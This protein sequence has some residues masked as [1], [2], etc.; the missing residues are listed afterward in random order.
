LE[1]FFSRPIK[2]QSYSWGTGT[3][4]FEKF[5]P[6]QDYFENPRVIN[7]IVNYNL[8]RCKLHVKFML[9]GNGFHYG[10]AIASYLP[11]H[12]FDEFTK[13]RAFFVEDVV[14][15][16]QRPHVY[17]DPTKSQG[18][19][20]TLPFVWEANA[21]NIPLQQW[22]DMGQIIIH[23]MQ[24]LKHANGASDSVTVSA[25]VWAT[26]YIVGSHCKRT[27]CTCTTIRRISP[28]SG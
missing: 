11:L 14:A 25:F 20:L 27:R 8:L 3:N 21:L 12:N 28:T 22:R 16:S 18:G 23:G 9:N 1:N 2:V 17:L 6:W 13:N 5:N 7:R 19:E 10:R 4:L 26:R 24:N 15:A